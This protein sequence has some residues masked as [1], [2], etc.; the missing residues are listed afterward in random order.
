M[1]VFKIGDI[2]YNWIITEVNYYVN[3]KGSLH[4][5]IKCKCGRTERVARRYEVH[6][7]METGIGANS[8][9]KECRYCIR[10]NNYEKIINE[11]TYKMYSDVIF[12]Y[13]SNA[14][15]RGLKFELTNEECVKL[16]KSNCKYCQIGPTNNGKRQKVKGDIRF[17]YTGID[18]VDSSKDYTIDNV[19]PCCKQ[20][21]ISKNDYSEE[22]FYEWLKRAYKVSIEGS[23]TTEQSGTPK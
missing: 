7:L 13:K 23:T 3:R 1:E 18:R 9:A 16:F 17:K 2:I 15:A 6:S 19:V 14:K 22:V 20:C 10:D 8:L 12:S 5:K 11:G 4:Y 21:N